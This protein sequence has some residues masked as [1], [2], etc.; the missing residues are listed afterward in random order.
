M[1]FRRA[2]FMFSVPGAKF[3]GPLGPTFG[4]GA[5]IWAQVGPGAFWAQNGAYCGPKIWQN[6]S[7]LGQILDPQWNV[8]WSQNGDH[9]GLKIL[10]LL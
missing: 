2:S 4:P 1:V 7:Q 8:F 9:S 6:G 10:Q 5:Q 3:G